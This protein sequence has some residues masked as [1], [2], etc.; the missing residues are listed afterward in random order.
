MKSKIALYAAA[1]T[2]VMLAAGIVVVLA[3]SILGV[4][5]ALALL[6]GVLRLVAGD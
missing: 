2:A 4:D 6:E 3:A 5:R 1:G